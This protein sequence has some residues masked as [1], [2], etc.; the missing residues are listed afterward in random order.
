MKARTSTLVLAAMLA[1]PAVAARAEAELL[2][3][4]ATAGCYVGAEITPASG[5]TTLV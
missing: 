1:L 3:P 4:P 2:F 5:A